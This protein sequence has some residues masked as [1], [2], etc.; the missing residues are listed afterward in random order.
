MVREAPRV[1]VNCSR[2]GSRGCTPMLSG[3]GAV[4]APDLFID[5]ML[6]RSPGPDFDA[7]V[8]TRYVLGIEVYRSLLE[9]P[10]QYQRPDTS[11]GTI[12]VWTEFAPPA[13]RKP[14]RAGADPTA[15]T[16]AVRT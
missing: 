9:T 11:C 3:G 7:I 14:R 1:R 10:P 12:V 16:T 13:K 8:D 6:V 15:D 4:C 2:G 5:D